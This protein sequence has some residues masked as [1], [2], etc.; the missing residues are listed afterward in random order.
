MPELSVRLL[1]STEVA[2]LLRCTAQ[3]VEVAARAGRLPGIQYG[4]EWL[5]PEDALFEALRLEALANLKAALRA[6]AAP[7]PPAEHAAGAHA[8]IAQPS[9]RKAANNSRTRPRPDLI[10]LTG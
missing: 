6:P 9:R 10:P 7:A 8:F 1:T 3:S 2:E 4:R 5:F